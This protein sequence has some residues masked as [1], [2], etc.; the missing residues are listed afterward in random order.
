MLK[1]IGHHACKN[2]GNHLYLEKIGLPVAL[3]S[4]DPTNE[5]NPFLGTGYYFWDYNKEMAKWWG[6]KQYG[7]NYYIFEAEI[8][9]NQDI[10]LDLVGNR[11]HM[12]WLIE[13]MNLFIE[14]DE[15]YKYWSIGQFIEYL[16]HISQEDEYQGIF[17]YQIIRAID[18]SAEDTNKIYDFYP[19]SKEY[20][21]LNPRIIIC[22][23]NANKDT[24]L[25]F[26]LIEKR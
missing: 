26:K 17:P 23:I 15:N 10:V 13:M 19:N 8:P 5:R 24:V 7:N 21:M 2:T 18:H 3:S 20:I 14:E 6:K 9:Y 16:K 25:S 4:Y 11:Q 12:E 22:A 1:L